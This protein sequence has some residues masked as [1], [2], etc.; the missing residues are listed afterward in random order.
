MLIDQEHDDAAVLAAEDEAIANMD[1]IP[2]VPVIPMGT[3]LQKLIE[4]AISGSPTPVH[5]QGEG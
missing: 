4:D 5:R 2:E 1:K 3:A